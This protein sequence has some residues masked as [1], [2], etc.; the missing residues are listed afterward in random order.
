MGYLLYISCYI[1]SNYCS[2]IKLSEKLFCFGTVALNG[3][4]ST[5][6]RSYIFTSPGISTYPVLLSK[7]NDR[8]ELWGSTAMLWYCLAV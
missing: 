7:R 6:A 5:G 1:V 4:L 2:V 3:L 8:L